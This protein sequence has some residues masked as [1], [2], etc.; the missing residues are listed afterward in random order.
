MLTF[1]LVLGC[2]G[3]GDGDTAGPTGSDAP[4]TAPDCPT[5]YTDA[6]GDGYGDAATARV[7]CE[8]V[9]GAVEAPGDCDDGDATAH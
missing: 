1:L 7:A 8:P 4:D 3:P 2:A 9:A 5:W 6:D